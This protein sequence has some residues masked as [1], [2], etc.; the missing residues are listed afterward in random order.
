MIAESLVGQDNFSWAVLIEQ[1]KKSLSPPD[2]KRH[3]YAGY[4]V[5][6]LLVSGSN[7][8]DLDDVILFLWS[9]RY[10]LRF[11]KEFPKLDDASKCMVGFFRVRGDREAIAFA[12]SP[13]ADETDYYKALEMLIV[14]VNRHYTSPL[15]DP[16]Q[17]Y[18]RMVSQTD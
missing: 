10:S 3:P 17:G 13:N 1:D 18:L 9:S 11:K 15:P 6:E 7:H 4:Q 2:D 5:T 16:P 12:R 8:F 14:E